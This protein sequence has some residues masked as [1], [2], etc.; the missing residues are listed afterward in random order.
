MNLCNSIGN[1][2]QGPQE[3][4]A[5]VDD[6]QFPIAFVQKKGMELISELS[7]IGDE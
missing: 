2:Y 1:G 7:I 6:I 3:G 4:N 5:F